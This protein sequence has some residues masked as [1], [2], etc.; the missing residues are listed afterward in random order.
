MAEKHSKS[1][2]GLAD[3]ADVDE[4][5]PFCVFSLSRYTLLSNLSN[6]KKKKKKAIGLASNKGQKSGN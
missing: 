5:H 3:V 6:R 4:R 1:S 2:G